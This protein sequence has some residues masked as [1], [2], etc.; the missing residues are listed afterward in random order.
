[1]GL[2]AIDPSSTGHARRRDD[3]E[4]L[5]K[6]TTHRLPVGFHHRRFVL[7]HLIVYPLGC[8]EDGPALRIEQP[9]FRR[10]VGEDTESDAH[11]AKGIIQRNGRRS[12]GSDPG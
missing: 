4:L 9:K 8:L 3:L 2:H 12:I 10:A 5:H 11:L 7:T 1:M 6:Q